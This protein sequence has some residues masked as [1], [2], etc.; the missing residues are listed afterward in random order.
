MWAT[1]AIFENL[2]IVDNHPMGENTPNLVTL[3]FVNI[4]TIEILDL[5]FYD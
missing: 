5:G 3:S 2:P 4:N 1:S